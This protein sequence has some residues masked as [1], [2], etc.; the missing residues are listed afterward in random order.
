M[1]LFKTLLCNFIYFNRHT[2]FGDADFPILTA[3]IILFHCLFIILFS[4]MTV[5]A[6]CIFVDRVYYPMPLWCLILL[7]YVIS[8]S[9]TLFL[10]YKT[11]CGKRYI[12]T[13]KNPK[14]YAKS[15]KIFSAC[16]FIVCIALI[17]VSG[18]LMWARNNGL[19]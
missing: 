10:Y 7:I 14:Y 8:G 18:Q 13:L 19:I 1:E 16:F 2:K 4:I 6:L 5:A 9:V 17:F 15:R 12:A 11:M 3:F